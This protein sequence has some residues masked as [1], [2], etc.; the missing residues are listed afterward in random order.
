M[1]IAQLRGAA[2]LDEQ[3]ATAHAAEDYLGG[4]AAALA[5]QLEHG[6]PVSQGSMDRALNTNKRFVRARFL[7]WIVLALTVMMISPARS[8]LASPREW[9]PLVLK[10]SQLP[11]LLGAPEDRL[12]VLAYSSS[13]LE[14]IPF[15]VDEGS[16]WRQLCS[17]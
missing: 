8:A 13:R 7:K 10:G 15:Q 11:A 2:C 12:A 1:A 16:P 9:Q 4:C 17:P 6:E 3:K 14:P 5:D